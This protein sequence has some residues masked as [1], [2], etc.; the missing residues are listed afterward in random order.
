M[1]ADPPR[2]SSHDSVSSGWVAEK[3]RWRDVV[4]RCPWLGDHRVVPARDAV[5]GLTSAMALYVF[6]HLMV[7]DD[8]IPYYFIWLTNWTGMVTAVYAVLHAWATRRAARLRDDE[9]AGDST[10]IPRGVHALWALK[11]I[12]PVAQLLITT[13]YW[14]VLWRPQYGPVSAYNVVA[15]GVLYSVT[16]VDFIALNRFTIDS[17]T[18]LANAYAYGGIYVCFNLVYTFI[19]GA[20]NHRGDRF[21]YPVTD[22]RDRPVVSVA[23]TAAAFLI[24]LPVCWYAMV[25]LTRMR[26]RRWFPV[27]DTEVTATVDSASVA[28]GGCA[29]SSRV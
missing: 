9:D 24:V 28:N 19:P 21:I 18:D 26:D 6:L 15:H 1:D 20:T 7:R 25:W 13:V 23:F 22:W 16:L 14:G 8:G 29:D 4:L 27:K 17:R 5:A 11:C 3:A 12:A 10:D 2:A